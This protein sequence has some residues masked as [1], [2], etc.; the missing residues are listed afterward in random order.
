MVTPSHSPSSYQ[1]CESHGINAVLP[2]TGL[3][4]GV[5]SFFYFLF[6]LHK[7][8]NST[9]SYK[10]CS[11]RRLPREHGIVAHIARVPYASSSL[12]CIFPLPPLPLLF[13][14]HSARSTASDAGHQRIA[15]ENRA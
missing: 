14:C 6:F 13:T 3:A 15:G 11:M 2:S 10:P 1:T 8:R 4:H 5:F 7:G 12:S 9:S